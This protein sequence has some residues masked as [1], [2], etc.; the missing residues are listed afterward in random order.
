LI[1]DRSINFDRQDEPKTI[2]LSA[3]AGYFVSGG[4]EVGCT[5]ETR[6]DRH[7]QDDVERPQDREQRFD[8]RSWIECN[9]HATICVS[10]RVDC[11]LCLLS[12]L[13]VE[14]D[15]LTVGGEEADQGT[16][17]L[18]HEVALADPSR[19]RIEHAED[20][21]AEREIWDEVTIAEVEVQTS[22]SASAQRSQLS[23]Q[24]AEVCAHE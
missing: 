5:R 10:N 19:A 9:A 15:Q 23:W 7:D 6:L 17:L 11:L 3:E 13:E 2:N 18:N 1:T 24:M 21:D 20:F 8:R 14:N 22:N 4:G 16:W 12:S